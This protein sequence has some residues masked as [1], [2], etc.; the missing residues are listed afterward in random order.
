[1][2]AVSSCLLLVLPGAVVVATDELLLDDDAAAA[3][4]FLYN[5][6]LRKIFNSCE[7]LASRPKPCLMVASAA[8]YD[9]D[10]S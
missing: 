4:A 9:F 6:T 5:L 8:S 2:V 1:M 10:S 3:A 7:L